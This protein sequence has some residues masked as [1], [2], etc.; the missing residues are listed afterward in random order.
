MQ[1]EKDTLREWDSKFAH[2]QNYLYNGVQ[3]LDPKN[4]PKSG[5]KNYP[6]KMTTVK[7]GPKICPKLTQEAS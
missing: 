5:P 7:V 3:S 2:L 6:Q 1:F 4:N